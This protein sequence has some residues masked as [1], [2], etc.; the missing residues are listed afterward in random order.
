VAS[1]GSGVTGQ[2]STQPEIATQL[3]RELGH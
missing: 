3:T 1:N 2:I